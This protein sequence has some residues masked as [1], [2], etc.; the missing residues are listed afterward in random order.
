MRQN[1]FRTTVAS[2]AMIFLF[3]TGAFAAMGEVQNFTFDG[4]GPND[5]VGEGETNRPDGRP[6]AMFSVNVSGF[7]AITGFMLRSEDNDS[8]W[9]TTPGNGI[10]GIRVK[11]SS[12]NVLT[13][14]DSHLSVV[15]FLMRKD[16]ELSVA[17][18]GTIARGG[19]FTV[20]ARF[21]DNSESSATITIKPYMTG[22]DV[23][24]L[25]ARWGEKGP[26]DL[27]GRNENL[28][29]DGRID[30][31]IR[32]E[33]MGEGVLESVEVRDI[34]DGNP[35]AAWDTIPGNGRWAIAVVK[36]NRIENRSDGSIDLRLSD[37]TVLDLWITDNGVIDAGRSRFEVAL[38]F[39]DGSYLQGFID[40]SISHGQSEGLEAAYMGEG[41]R[42]LVGRNEARS[43][44]GKSDWRVNVKID[45]PGTVTAMKIA[46]V[47]GPGG[48]WD[49]I[50]KNGKW[51]LAVTQPNGN[52]LNNSDGSINIRVSRP[53]D[54]V[55]W[56]ENNGS[57]DKA[58][59]RSLLTVT[60]DDGRLLETEIQPYSATTYSGDKD[61]LEARFVGIGN[62]DFVGKNENLRGDQNRDSRF[63]IKFRGAGTISAIHLVNTTKGGEWDTVP[64]NGKW[65]IA[66]K[67]PGGSVLNDSNG[68]VRL[69]VD[70]T[71]SLELWVQDNGTLGNEASAFRITIDFRDGSTLKKEIPADRGDDQ[72][73]VDNDKRELTLYGPRQA[74][75]SDYVGPYDR[76]QKNGKL[77]W[78]FNLKIRGKGTVKAITLKN[79]GAS[80]EWDTIPGNGRWTLAIRGNGNRILNK[81][82]GSVSFSVPS[83]HNVYLF[84]ENNGT[85]QLSKSRFELVV[86]WDDGTKSTAHVQ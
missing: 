2:L 47:K 51:L 74:S 14:S 39:S 16:F 50:P 81:S 46:N 67:Q 9:D 86:T 62:F 75:S 41:S 21:V 63:D 1:A 85:L 15:P 23:R 70:G 83:E 61:F 36:G 38:R 10:W 12:G 44:N 34:V 4:F 24:L 26:R 64:N 43:G 72:L 18:N 25:S 60:Y 32:L 78:Y 53:T 35:T 22:S 29:G 42:D 65:L 28:R 77:D 69:S 71:A 48:E 40:R 37:R 3:A 19:E 68:S 45:N 79:L 56:M 55:I 82:D 80:G 52:I 76:L 59:T 49:T 20:T 84:V 57:L 5:L 11:D 6:D 30:D 31:H 58:E 13:E 73:D 33:L 8:A 7:G 17:D 27:T 54:L 66:V